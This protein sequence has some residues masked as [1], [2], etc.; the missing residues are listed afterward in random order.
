MKSSRRNLRSAT[1]LIISSPEYQRQI[2]IILT[3]PLLRGHT[4]A[5]TMLGTAPVLMLD[6]ALDQPRPRASGSAGC[7]SR[8][9]SRP[10]FRP[11]RATVSGP[12]RRIRSR[13]A[14]SEDSDIEATSSGK[15]RPRSKRN[16][17]HLAPSTH[18]GSLYSRGKERRRLSAT[19]ALARFLQK[20]GVK[21]NAIG[22]KHA[23][24]AH[25]DRGE[26]FGKTSWCPAFG[27]GSRSWT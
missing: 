22:I 4:H 2:G 15:H 17:V 1:V 12:P 9:P 6:L 27:R 8:W 24:V 14:R 11:S 13:S 25:S 16:P 21:K 19:T 20:K 7:G 18:A 23:G 10:G 5:I 26:T 3:Q